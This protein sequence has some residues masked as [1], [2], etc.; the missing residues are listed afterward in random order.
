MKARLYSTLFFLLASVVIS[1][2]YAFQKKDNSNHWQAPAEAKNVINPYKGPAATEKGKVL[3]QK[4][5]VVCHGNSGKGDGVGAVSLSTKP[6]DHTASYV[7][8]I[9]DG[10]LYWMITNG[11][12]PMPGYKTSLTDEQ[13]WQLVDYIRELGRK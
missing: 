12:S 3:Y 6:A 8:S 5:C 10:A 1:V 4:M 7:Q 9:S 11:K 2:C 13:R